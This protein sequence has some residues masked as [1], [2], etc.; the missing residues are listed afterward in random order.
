MVWP[1]SVRGGQV[2]AG[3]NQGCIGLQSCL[4]ARSL[5]FKEDWCSVVDER[6]RMCGLWTLMMFLV[7][8]LAIFNSSDDGGNA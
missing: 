1:R 3:D 4:E 7:L 6:G 5:S 8:C 2:A